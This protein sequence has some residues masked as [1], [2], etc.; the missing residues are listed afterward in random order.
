[1]RY[2]LEQKETQDPFKV[3]AMGGQSGLGQDIMPGMHGLELAAGHHPNDLARYRELIGM[4]GSGVPANLVD[5]ETLEPNLQLLSIL[6]VR[7]VI[8]PAYRF[9]ALPAGEPVMGTTLGGDRIF[10]VVYEIPTLPRARLV[11]EAVVLSDDEAVSYILSPDFRPADEVVL[12]EASPIA[13][14]GGPVEGEV[15]WVEKSPNRFRL[16]VRSESPALLVLAENWYPAWKAEV[17]GVEAPVLRAN[18]TLRAVPVP[19]GESEVEI[20]FDSGTLLGP[21]LITLASLA[22]V[23]GVLFIRPR[24]SPAETGSTRGAS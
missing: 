6:N 4:A 3:L 2:L 22:L 21:F 20:F 23:F 18:H 19:S 13:L 1:T 24:A 15:R 14:P 7:Y 10:E 11:G 5:L 8:W 12:T 17:G 9:G 16:Q